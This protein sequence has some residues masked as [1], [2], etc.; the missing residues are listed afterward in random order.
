M[1]SVAGDFIT[2]AVKA[3]VLA[4][5]SGML[6]S[7]LQEESLGSDS[8]RKWLKMPTSVR[9]SSWLNFRLTSSVVMVSEGGG[10]VAGNRGALEGNGA[11]K[12][13]ILLPFFFFLPWC[14]QTSRVYC[15]GSSVPSWWGCRICNGMSAS[16]WDSPKSYLVRLPQFP[17][18]A[19]NSIHANVKV[20][21]VQRRY[22]HSAQILPDARLDPLQTNLKGLHDVQPCV[23]RFHT[24]SDMPDFS[25]GE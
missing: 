5:E 17:L 21:N 9:F 14:P 2:Y 19:P 22:P 6:F 4:Q 12:S 20:V 24:H 15:W 8:W 11:I 7:T 3:T 16:P 13:V 10:T 1:T 23:N 18:T 25:A